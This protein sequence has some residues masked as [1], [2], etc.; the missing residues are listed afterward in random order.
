MDVTMQE[1]DDCLA[2]YKR[3]FDER[4]AQL[5][6]LDHAYQT[7]KQELT[8]AIAMCAGAITAFQHLKDGKATTL[9]EDTNGRQ[10]DNST[11]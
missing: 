10:E 1:I 2:E 9:K 11:E 4:E 7:A 5:R 8:T 6:E 3:Q